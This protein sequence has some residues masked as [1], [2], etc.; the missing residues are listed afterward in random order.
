MIILLTIVF[1]TL[2]GRF[3]KNLTGKEIISQIYE[4][5]RLTTRYAILF[6]WYYIFE[7]QDEDKRK[8]AGEYLNRFEIKAGHYKS[9]QRYNGGLSIPVERTTASIK[10][11][12]CLKARCNENGIA[13]TPIFWNFKKGQIRKID[14]QDKKLTKMDLFIKPLAGQRE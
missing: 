3:I 5:I 9:L 2:N 1:I 12:A 8:H 7:L 6:P 13:T 10:D 14:W 4:Q 11:K